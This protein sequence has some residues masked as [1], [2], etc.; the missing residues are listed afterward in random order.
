MSNV[1]AKQRAG[2]PVTITSHWRA[3]GSLSFT[4]F[5]ATTRGA[6]IVCAAGGVGDTF[7][8]PG[9]NAVRAPAFAILTLAVVLAIGATGTRPAPR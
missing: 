1:V 6:A 9:L 4:A 5:H 7:H 3:A 8:A 2:R